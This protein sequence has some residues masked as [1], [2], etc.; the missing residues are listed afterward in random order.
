MLPGYNN[1][2][3]LMEALKK[4]EDKD[5][6]AGVELSEEESRLCV[7]SWRNDCGEALTLEEAESEAR[8]LLHFFGKLE[9]DLHKEEDSESGS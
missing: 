7:E 2:D 1:I 8:R 3:E 9:E 4:G 5:Y 6:L